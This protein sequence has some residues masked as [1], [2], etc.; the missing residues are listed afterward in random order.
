VM[1]PFFLVAGARVVMT[2][3]FRD[4]VAYSI[5][6]PIFNEA[7]VLPTLID[8]LDAVLASLDGPDR[9]DIC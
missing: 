1:F 2:E 4:T 9:S 8:R 3:I 6:I 7:L 5:V